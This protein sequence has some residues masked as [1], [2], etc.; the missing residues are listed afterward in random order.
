M[1]IL[2]FDI[3]AIIIL[4]ILIV[5]LLF[6]KMLSGRTNILYGILLVH[7]VASA[8]ADFWSEA[9]GIWIPTKTSNLVTRLLLTYIY[10]FLRNLTTPLYQLFICSI[11]D[12]WHKLKKDRVLQTFLIVPGIV[13]CVTLLTNPFHHMVFYFDE[14]LVY[15]R[16]VLIYVLYVASFFYLICGF[17]YLMRYRRMLTTDKFDPV[18]FPLPRFLTPFEKNVKTSWWIFPFYGDMIC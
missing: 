11:T 13:I 2:Y 14:A 8:L 10:F 16:G 18:W 17:V 4:L 3:A 9:Y 6:R 1:K 5:S 12:T 7:I 15:H